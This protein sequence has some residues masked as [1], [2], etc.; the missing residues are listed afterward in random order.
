M[1]SLYRQHW[2]ATL[3]LRVGELC[4]GEP[5]DRAAGAARSTRRPR[6]AGPRT[7]RRRRYMSLA[8]GEPA[9]DDLHAVHQHPDP[10]VAG[11]VESIGARRVGSSFLSSAPKR[12][13]GDRGA[14]ATSPQSKSILLS[15][16]DSGRSPLR[17]VLSKYSART[18]RAAAA[19]ARQSSR[20][21]NLT[22]APRLPRSTRA[23]F[24][25]CPRCSWWVTV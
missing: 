25:E 21:S 22:T 6:C 16:R 3:G 23:R 19:A 5:G 2:T 24:G 1:R 13:G 15:L 11:H 12:V 20:S 17:V 18:A 8:T 7:T 10:V 9:V 4:L 14:R